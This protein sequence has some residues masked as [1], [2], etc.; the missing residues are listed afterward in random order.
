MKLSEL[1]LEVMR[2]VWRDKEVIVPDLHA[3]L[4]K[5]REITYA[6]VKTIVNRLEEKGAIARIRTYGRTIL[7]GPLV[8]ENALVKPIVKNV[9]RRLFADNARPLISHLIRDEK[10]SMEDLEYLKSQIAE[11]QEKL[12]RKK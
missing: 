12:E 3:E 10:L 2:L 7:Y 5:D 8:N 6:T 4:E 1:E 9:L 11:K